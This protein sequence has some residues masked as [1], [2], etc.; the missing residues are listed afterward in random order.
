MSLIHYAQNLI[1]KTQLMKKIYFVI[2]LASLISSQLTAQTFKA[3]NDTIDLYPGVPK[4]FNLL[5]ND[6]VPAGDSL[7]ILYTNPDNNLLIITQIY[8]GI[9]TYLLK[10]KWGF[11]G[12]LRGTYTIQDKTIN[13]VSSAA[14]LFRI[15][16]HSYDSLDI[17]DR[18]SVV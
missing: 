2:V 3:I 4:T 9:F 16:D 7:K 6:T 5:A 10:P 8:K 12:D 18:K 13:K 1:P 15:H 11:N 17:K 14:I